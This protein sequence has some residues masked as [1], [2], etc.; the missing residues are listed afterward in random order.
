[1]DKTPH[2]R[3]RFRIT[4]TRACAAAGL[5][6][7]AG[8]GL[9]LAQQPGASPGPAARLKPPKA[10]D[11]PTR[12]VVGR[13][14]APE[15]SP[16]VSVHPPGA[17]VQPATRPTYGATPTQWGTGPARTTQP[18]A[19][20]VPQRE[21]GLIEG[22]WQDLKGLVTGQPAGATP[23][24]QHPSTTALPRPQTRPQTTVLPAA[25]YA[26]PPA[27]RWYGWG[28]TTP[29][30]NQY[31][32][33]GVYPRGSA[34]WYSQTGATPGA[35]PVPV[36]NPYRSEP[37][38]E[39][40]AYAR[41]ATPD[42]TTVPGTRLV[43]GDAPPELRYG[44]T[45]TPASV[46]VNTV[47]VPPGAPPVAV[48][49]ADYPPVIAQSGQPSSG[50]VQSSA[51]DEGKPTWQRADGESMPFVNP[52]P[53]VTV[54]RGMEPKAREPS[55]EDA[56]KAACHAKAAVTEVRQTGP[57]QLVVKVRA[58]TP[59]DARA[60]FAALSEVPALRPYKV[61]FEADIK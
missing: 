4:P 9:A 21:P 60:A 54:I 31:A 13:G 42:A 38:A 30:A 55:L 58:A 18:K 46:P 20:S 12:T 8:G 49:Q 43:T 32:P 41:G 57:T 28:T 39:P 59:A 33:T 7:L 10:L 11:E 2:T 36:M 6:A 15:S 26:G 35:F 29:G 48:Q 5:F 14:A 19:A 27:Y 37:N 34:N 47:P 24:F 53:T 52:P 51:R 3:R 50:V 61:E 16:G 56:V 1:M 40:P 22:A 44:P 17:A 25:V 45:P 23:P